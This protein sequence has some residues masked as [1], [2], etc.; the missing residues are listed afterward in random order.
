MD[1]EGVLEEINLD[2]LDLTLTGLFDT[3]NGLFIK[4]TEIFRH[5]SFNKS[6]ADQN[7]LL[8]GASFVGQDAS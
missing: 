3:T 8:L 6:P 2:W 5:L 7:S 4:Y 1:S